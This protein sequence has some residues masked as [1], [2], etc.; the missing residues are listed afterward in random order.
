MR[1]VALL[2]GIN[3]GG[4][5]KVDMTQLKAVFDDSGMSSTRTYINSGNV[6][7]DSAVRSK[8]RLV[9]LLEEGIAKR[10]GFHVPV[11]LRDLKSMRALHEAIPNR[12][13]DDKTM[14]CY[15]MF[16][17]ADVARPSVL[18]Q[19]QAKPGL[20]DVLYASGSIVWRVDRKDVTRSGMAKLMATPLYKRM[21]IRSVNTTRKLLELMEAP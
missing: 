18:R 19:L 20:D 8:A 21:T 7:F 13:T 4:K 2:R 12:W 3:V 11:L 14:R 6:V 17:W 16:L 10:F 5:N 15:V 1:Y 9:Q